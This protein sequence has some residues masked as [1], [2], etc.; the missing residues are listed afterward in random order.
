MV[1]PTRQPVTIARRRTLL[2]ACLLGAPVPALLLA[3]ASRAAGEAEVLVTLHTGD[4]RVLHRSGSAAASAGLKLHGAAIVQTTPG[5]QLLRLEWPGGTAADLGPDSQLLF[6]PGGLASGAPERRAT[7]YLLRGWLKL[8]AVAGEAAPLVM[9][10][11]DTA[12]LAQGALVQYAG[13]GR[14]WL[15]A[16]SGSPQVAERPPRGAPV[17]LAAGQLFTRVGSDTAQVLPR[18]PGELLREVPRAF[19]D[20]LPR[21]YAAL[22]A[23]PA[24]QREAPAPTYAELR[25]WLAAESA[26][27]RLLP[28]QFEHWAREPALRAALASPDHPEWALVLNS[29]RGERPGSTRRP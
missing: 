5:A 9:T 3:A 1:P 13:Q 22:K 23:S 11:F 20:T 7:L 26:V 2:R 8:S 25:E 12:T 24:P 28:A 19:R 14:A 27:R 21:R 15:L 18:P 29:E 6:A 10:L 4:A 17:A 16:E